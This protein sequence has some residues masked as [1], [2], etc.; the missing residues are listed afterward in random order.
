ML[1]SSKAKSQLDSDDERVF[2]GGEMPLS[3][4][5]ET[6]AATWSRGR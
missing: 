3:T 5:G 4:A 2:P 6:P 1:A